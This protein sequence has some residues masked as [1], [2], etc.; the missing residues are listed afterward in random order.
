MNELPDEKLVELCKEGKRDAFNALVRRYQT[1]I[2][3]VIRRL[4]GD[5][6]DAEDVAQDVFIRA[7][8]AI[9]EFRGDS[10]FFTWLY[11]I[12]MNLGLN[13][14]R[15]KKLRTF[16]K[17]DDLGDIHDEQSES[18]HQELEKEE[19]RGRIKRAIDSLP[20]KQKAVFILRFYDELTY[21][22]IAAVMRKSTGGMKANY[23][24]AVRK[25]QEYL[26]HE[27]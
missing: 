16:F 3:W 4:I 18:P 23:F 1:K 12:A 25:I 22:E 15:K 13:H 9:G 19:M 14:L 21:E 26:K 17:L 2:Y 24:H 20:E 6:D 8:N 27:M 11:K 7:Y 5:A 10:Q